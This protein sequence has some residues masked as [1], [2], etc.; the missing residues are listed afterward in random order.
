MLSDYSCFRT[1]IQ[2]TGLSLLFFICLS[3]EAQTTSD[4]QKMQSLRRID[5]LVSIAR[6]V[7]SDSVKSDIYLRLLGL[8]LFTRHP[9]TESWFSEG[10]QSA[11]RW[12][13]P[14]II[15][16]YRVMRI[17]LYNATG[18][19]EK[20]NAAAPGVQEM[21]R[22]YPSP[23]AEVSLLLNWGKALAGVGQPELAIGKFR[24]AVDLAN[25][26]NMPDVAIVAMTNFAAMLDSQQRHSEMKDILQNIILIAESRNLVAEASQAKV[27]LALV[28]SKLGNFGRSQ[29][30]LIEAI[31][32]YRQTG[33]EVLQAACCQNL[34]HAYLQTR[35]Y[36]K[37]LQV[38]WEGIGIRTKLKDRPGLGKMYN[39]V[40][41]TYLGMQLFDSSLYYITKA[42]R[43]FDSVQVNE[44]MDALKL[45]SDVLAAQQKFREA[46]AALELSQRIKDSM[47]VLADER[48]MEKELRS[49][50]SAYQDSLGRL[51]KK[52]VSSSSKSSLGWWI[53]ILLGLLSVMGLLRFRRNKEKSVLAPPPMNFNSEE[54]EQIVRQIDQTRSQSLQALEKLMHSE[55]KQSD[56]FWNEFLLLFSRIYPD[57]FKM[58]KNRFPS[59]NANE[60]KLCAMIKSGMSTEMIG[61]VNG[62]EEDT[63]QRARYR[64]VRKLGIA[65]VGELDHFIREHC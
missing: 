14:D 10:A 7:E 30:L 53:F 59:L 4:I 65:S 41:R 25:A 29:S 12:G 32:F 48:Q 63:V 23:R 27:N 60:L 49:F 15:L 6:S 54:L 58:V 8:I 45:K 31:R 22:K 9:E 34:G 13:N 3:T 64:L 35:E 1:K 44:R 18:D 55:W 5:S 19:F 24:E 42:V 16:R 56:A 11:E 52:L 43:L 26:S 39:N 50:Q 33:N 28:E 37:S 21:F 40:A 20:T 51:S 36:D 62:V 47:N 17:Y 38:L 46:A 2:W 57:F 61:D